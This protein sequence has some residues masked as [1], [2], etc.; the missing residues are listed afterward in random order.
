MIT[1]RLLDPMK[2][3]ARITTYWCIYIPHQTIV[4]APVYLRDTHCTLS[5][6]QGQ[7]ARVSKADIDFLKDEIAGPGGLWRIAFA[8]PKIN[9]LATHLPLSVPHSLSKRPYSDG[10]LE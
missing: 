10:F 6:E 7:Y 9:T 3:K 4:L 8:A 5:N 2:T 1:P